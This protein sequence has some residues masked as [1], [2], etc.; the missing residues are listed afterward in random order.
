MVRITRLGKAG[1]PPEYQWY[2]LLDWEKLGNHQST[3]GTTGLG[4]AGEPPE[5]QWYVLLDWEKLGNHQSTNGMYY[6]TGK[7][8]V[9]TRVPMVRITRLGKAG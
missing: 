5:Y 6:S 2:V 3:N 8:W 7:S 9:T 4:K 1:E